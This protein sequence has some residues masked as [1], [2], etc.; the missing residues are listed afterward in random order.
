LSARLAAAVD[1]LYRDVVMEPER[2][3]ED[4][5]GEWLEAVAL[6]AEPVDRD[7]AKQLRRAVRSAVKLQSFWSAADA[8]RRNAE[9]SWR[10]RVDIAVGIP[11]WRPP[12][13]LAMSELDQQPSEERFNDAR[14]R[15]R[16]VHGVTWLD[17]ATFSE[18]SSAR[19][20]DGDAR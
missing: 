20:G 4:A 12:L 5:L 19:S 1:D 3:N 15:F 7:Q 16:V 6:D 10:A 18:W 13:E 2:W 9:P 14:D 11:A 17:G 8:K